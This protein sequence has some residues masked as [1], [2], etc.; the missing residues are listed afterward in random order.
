MRKLEVKQSAGEIVEVSDVTMEGIVKENPFVVVDCWA[1]WCAPCHMIAPAIEELAG[2]YAGRIVFGKLN[3][4]ENK[5]T[6]SRYEVMAI[7][8][9]LV[10]RNGSLVDRITGA[11]PKERLE[12]K[13]T[14][15][16]D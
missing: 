9:L 7:P 13:L 11:L 4:D 12:P 16:L 8:T 2:E 10:F 1:P 14:K 15:H 6:S 5:V 3:I